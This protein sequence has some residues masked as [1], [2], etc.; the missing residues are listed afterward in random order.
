LTR[1]I[2]ALERRKPE[3]ARVAVAG[4]LGQDEEVK[5]Q[6]LALERLDGLLAISR[7][8]SVRPSAQR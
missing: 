1:D 2:V 4:F 5:E 7:Y 3:D 8:L 6:K